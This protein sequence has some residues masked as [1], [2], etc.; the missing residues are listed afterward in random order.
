MV[1]EAIISTDIDKLVDGNCDILEDL[2][3]ELA[4]LPELTE[5]E[6]STIYATTTL[7]EFVPNYLLNV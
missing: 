4:D 2:S 6:V 3:F 7:S 1:N 5:T